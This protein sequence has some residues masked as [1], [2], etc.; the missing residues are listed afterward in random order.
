MGKEEVKNMDYREAVILAKQG[1]EEGYHF[2]Y[3]TTYKS[4]YYLALQYMKNEDAAQDVLQEAYMRAFS[5]LDMLEQPE[6]FSGWLGKIVAN[7]AKN[8]LQKRNPLLFSEMADEEEDAAF[9][10]EQEDESPEYQPELSYTRRE[11][12]ELVHE[13]IDALSEEQRICIL[14]YEIEGISIR[15]IATALNCSEN[16]VKSRLNYGRKNLRKRAE[17]LQNKGYKLYGLAPLPLLLYLL[18]ADE[19]CLAAEGVLDVGKEQLETK[20]FSQSQKQSGQGN[21]RRDFGERSVN[22]N[23]MGKA[24]G[25][26]VKKAFIHTAV[27]KLTVTAVSL[28]VV[29]AVTYMG[30]FHVYQEKKAAGQVEEVVEE[31]PVNPE[32]A[33]EGTPEVSE[34]ALPETELKNPTVTPEVEP[35]VRELMEEEYPSLIGNGVTREEMEHILAYGPQEI[36]EKGFSE[37]E[38]VQFV[39]LLCEGGANQSGLIEYYG[40]NSQW[41]YMYSLVDINRMLS[42]F[43]TYQMS[44]ENTKGAPNGAYVQGDKFIFIPATMG[45]TASAQITSSE[46]EEN[47]IRIFYTYHYKNFDTREEYQKSKKATL[48]PGEDGKYRIVR[49]EEAESGK[50]EEIPETSKTEGSKERE[51][52]FS[53]RDIYTEVL[54]SVQNGEEGYGFTAEAGTLTGEYSYFLCDMDGDSMQDLVVGEGIDGGPFLCNNVRVYSCQKEGEGYRLKMIPGEVTILIDAIQPS[55]GYGFLVQSISRGTGDIDIYRISVENGTLTEGGTERRYRLGDAE[56][57]AFCD[58]STSIEWKS[59]S[60]ISGLDVLS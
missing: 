38:Y 53:V 24:A 47:E 46:Y 33:V 34:E 50:K 32:A 29:C 35:E 11:T 51:N 16:T 18:H 52:L 2:L 8:M 37:K 48:H 20:L 45:H 13:M 3:E 56:Y 36:P 54:Q 25:K 42:A 14:M 44:E 5:R 21:A 58:G 27:G 23:V 19:E 22:R 28:A 41:E 57:E 26:T 59:I 39:N 49:I 1:R 7:T 60:D 43:T 4:K 10:Y 55:E 6:A 17:E 30:V 12:Q 15:E 31:I 9:L 40:T